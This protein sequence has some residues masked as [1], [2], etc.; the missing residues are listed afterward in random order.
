MLVSVKSCEGVF[1]I[2]LDKLL[3]EDDGLKDEEEQLRAALALGETYRGGGG[4]QP[5]FTIRCV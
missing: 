3:A 1:I 5:L 2:D 4:A